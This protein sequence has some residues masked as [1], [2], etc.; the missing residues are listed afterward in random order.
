RPTPAPSG[1]SA[2]LPPRRRGRGIAWL[3]PRSLWSNEAPRDRQGRSDRDRRPVEAPERHRHVLVVAALLL[4]QEADGD[5]LAE[6][7]ALGEV[8]PPVDAGGVPAGGDVRG[9]LVQLVAGGGG[10][11]RAWRGAGGC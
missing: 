7:Q 1:R 4:L 6:Q 11:P 5:Q 8:A 3:P 9:Q 2:S 10:L